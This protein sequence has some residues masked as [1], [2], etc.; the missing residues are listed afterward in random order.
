MTLKVAE[1]DMIE[2][3]QQDDPN[4]CKTPPPVD[5]FSYRDS[6]YSSLNSSYRKKNDA[7]R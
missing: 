2:K 7:I 4:Q 3:A 1:K 6:R 5:L